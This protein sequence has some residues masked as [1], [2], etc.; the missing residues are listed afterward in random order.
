[1]SKKITESYIDETDNNISNCSENNGEILR[2]DNGGN[3][4]SLEISETSS[5][6]DSEASFELSSQKNALNVACTNARSLVHK[7]DSLITLFEE[8]N[9]HLA[10]LTET[11]LTA[12][13]CPVRV[14]DDLASGSDIKLI[15]RDRGSRGG[16]VAVCYNPTKTRLTKFPIECNR[17]DKVEIVAATGNCNL[18][19]RK[20]V[21]I[22]VYLAA[23]FAVQTRTR[24]LVTCDIKTRFPDAIIFTGG[25][26]NKKKLSVFTDAFGDL[27]PLQAGPTIPGA[28]LS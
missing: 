6:T 17:N 11:W 26:F 25:D 5:A 10:I 8:N 3:I 19:Q 12:K 18:S 23:T 28:M 15:R 7:D 27:L 1:M 4:N 22:A 9:L 2:D 14:M 13:A 21:A 24:R 16:G 20:I